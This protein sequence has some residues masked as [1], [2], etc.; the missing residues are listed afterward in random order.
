MLLILM[1]HGDAEPPGAAGERDLTEKGRR[2]TRST[3]KQLHAAGFE[4]EI[5]YHSG[6]K[7][8]AETARFLAESAGPDA[9]IERIVGLTPHDDVLDM[10]NEISRISA[11]AAVVGHMPHLMN[12]LFHLCG[13][14]DT[15]PFGTAHAAV[16]RCVDS[17]WEIEKIFRPKP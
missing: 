17:R 1:R 11:P 5:I 4:P 9:T 16:L 13:F 15:P 3:G 10:A 6:K 12:L 8:A 2:D 7:R 14:Q